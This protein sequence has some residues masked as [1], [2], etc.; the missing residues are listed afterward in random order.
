MDWDTTT[1]QKFQVKIKNKKYK[2]KKVKLIYYSFDD[3]EDRSKIK[4]FNENRKSHMLIRL[5][6]TFEGLYIEELRSILLI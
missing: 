6:E 4:I 5:Y 3:I 2:I 1:Y